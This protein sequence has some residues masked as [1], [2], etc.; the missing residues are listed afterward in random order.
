M[1]MDEQA[2]REIMAK[3]VYVC[4]RNLTDDE[5]LVLSTVAITD[6]DPHGR[7]FDYEKVAHL[8]TQD[9][10]TRMHEETKVALFR[11]VSTRFQG[12]SDGN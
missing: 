2:M 6:A 9:N 12:E 8:F 5:L 3:T 11:V 4:T 1:M 7:L 10:G